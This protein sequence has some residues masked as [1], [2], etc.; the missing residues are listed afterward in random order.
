MPTGP[1][2]PMQS[3]V[4]DARAMLD[5]LP[6]CVARCVPVRDDRG[7]IIDYHFEYINAAA[8]AACTQDRELSGR[9]L[10]DVAPEPHG[11]DLFSACCGVVETGRPYEGRLTVQ[12]HQ[13]KSQTLE[14]RASKLGD[15]VLLTWQPCESSD[16]ADPAPG[17]LGAEPFRRVLMEM[18]TPALLHDEDGRIVLVNRAWTEITGYAHD[19]I[20]TMEHWTRLAYGENQPGALARLE[21]VYRQSERT[22]NGVWPVRTAGGQERMWQF[23]AAPVGRDERG[24]RL[25]LSTVVDVTDA[26]RAQ[27]RIESSERFTRRVL[28]GVLAFV[29]VLSLDGT[30]LEANQPAIDAAGLPREAFIGKPFWDAYWWSH[31]PAVQARLREAVERAG[32]GEVVRYDVEI[33]VANEGRLWIDFQLAPLRNSQ[34]EVTHLVPSATD[35]SQRFAEA[36]AKDEARRWLERVAQTTPDVIFVLD[37]AESR[38]VYSND[39]I[40]QLLGH[41]PE[42]LAEF[43]DVLEDLVVPED[44]AQVRAFFEGMRTAAASETRVNEHRIRHRDGSV[45]WVEA[46]VTPFTLAADGSVTQVL[47]LARDVTAQRAADRALHESEERARLAQRI[48]GVGAFDWDIVNN[49]NRWSP[50]LETLYGLEPGSFE[51]TLEAWAAL[52]HPDDLEAAQAAVAHSLETGELETEWRVLDTEGSV[53]WVEARGW[54]ERDDTG[55]PLRMIGVNLDITDRKRHEAQMRTVMAELNHRVKNTIAVIQALARQTLNRS[56][57]LR[58]FGES[59]EQRLASIARA[60]GLLTAA[61]WSGASLREIIRGELSPRI[62]TEGQLVLEGPAVRLP[63]KAVLA[64]HMIVHELATN[65]AKYGALSR[66]DGRVRVSWTIDQRGD[67]RSMLSI[68]WSEH[69]PCST[70]SVTRGEAGYGTQLMSQLVEYELG[71]RFLR[72]L[73]ACGL[74]CQVE[75]PLPRDDRTGE[76]APPVA[77]GPRP[78]AVAPAAR[79]GSRAPAN[80]KPPRVLVVEDTL[81]LAMALCEELAANGLEVLGPAPTLDSAMALA[82]EPFDFAVLD[83]DLDG[84][85]VYPLARLLRDRGAPFAML[86]GYE[87]HDLPEDLR[88][89]AILGKPVS[90]DTL[91]AHLRRVLGAW[92]AVGSS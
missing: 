30:L 63:P 58:A 89:E 53:L 82:C 9:R 79:A 87:R 31:D 92:D 60:H 2:P 10:R 54:V 20:P 50:E 12:G 70:P 62:A 65:A 14:I 55:R 76:P 86:T 64:V 49:I 27:R 11:A 69:A 33:R 37:L 29:G 57:D 81:A 42:E 8:R 3:T 73:D 74:G 51:G 46:R 90:P 38:T 24:R 19:D 43:S 47:G 77:S 4:A 15:G 78:S 1:T 40:T 23:Y 36:R 18:A 44:L 17:P 34:G 68:A 52:V 16:S 7:R 41:S 88:Q 28:D 32:R 45:R 59:F 48:G 84:V 83:V 26:H 91:L 67:A 35:L 22:D 72:T 13:G 75:F 25:V 5:A 6:H 71:G 39:S 21:E 66:D 85:K 56:T 61:D 80:G